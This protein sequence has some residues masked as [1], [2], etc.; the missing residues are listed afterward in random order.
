MTPRK[1]KDYRCLYQES[2]HRGWHA[3]WAFVRSEAAARKAA[4]V[5]L[6]SFPAVSEV[7]IV[8]EVARI[9]RNQ[10]PEVVNLPTMKEWL[11]TEA[12]KEGVGSQAIYNRLARGR[13]PEVDLVRKNKRM[14]YV[15]DGRKK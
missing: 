14:V 4:D 15:R 12:E 10:R 5:L 7:S 9:K 13:Y 8:Q 11:A 3:P 1:T 2:S 6:K